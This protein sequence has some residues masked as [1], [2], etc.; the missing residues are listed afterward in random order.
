MFAS[1]FRVARCIH[2]HT[3]SFLFWVM[4]ALEITRYFLYKLLQHYIPFATIWRYKKFWKSELFLMILLCLASKIYLVTSRTWTDVIFS[5]V[6][7]YTFLVCL[8]LKE[9]FREI[10]W[11]YSVPQIPWRAFNNMGCL[12]SEK[13]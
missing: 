1:C 11:L 5:V 12:K 8:F 13:F 2:T 7:L 3:I 10:I 6:L 9:K 4:S